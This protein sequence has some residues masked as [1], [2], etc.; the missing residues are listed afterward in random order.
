MK[1]EIALLIIIFLFFTQGLHSDWINNLSDYL[2]TEAPSV[3]MSFLKIGVGARAIALAGAYSSITDDPTAVYWNPGGIVNTKGFNTSFNHISLFDDVNYEFFALSSSD[4][5]QGVGIGLGGVFYGGME[6]RGEQPSQEPIGTYNAYSFILKACYGHRFGKDIVSGFAVNAI[7]ERIYTY[8]THTFTFDYGMQYFPR[9][10]KHFV[11]SLNFNN[12]GPKVK[13]QEDTF[14][15]PLTVKLGSSY[16]FKN[17]KS[18]FVLSTEVSKSIDSKITPLIGIELGFHPAKFRI[19]YNFNK[20]N[21]FHFTTGLGIKY[22]FLTFDYSVVPY[23]M[24]M[25]V[26]QC[27][28]LNLAF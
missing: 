18:N 15:L 16:M 11:F 25:G 9:L 26:K 24:D 23:L 21:I 19:G 8:S 4:G 22:K 12:L 6:L 14:R 7:L 5:N 17:N 13:Y 2:N 3:G 1:K 27:V 20:D 10:L 28:S